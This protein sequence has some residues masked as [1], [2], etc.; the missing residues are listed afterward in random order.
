MTLGDQPSDPFDA[1]RRRFL[2]AAALG[3]AAP[4]AVT[5]RSTK[6]RAAAAPVKAIAFDG[7]VVFDP[8][9]VYA[10]LEEIFPG[11]GA[12]V[13][14]LWRTRQFEYTWLRTLTGRYADFR[15]V[16]AEALDYAAAASQLPLENAQ[17]TRLMAAW[18]G[19]KA[20]PDAKPALAAL[21]Q[22]G[23][24][25]GFLSNLTEGMLRDAVASAGLDGIFEQLLSTDRVR[26]F[27]PDPR[28]YRMGMDGFGLDR[29]EIVFAAF[30]G[31]DAA[32]AKAFGYRTYWCNRLGQPVEQLGVTPDA[33]GGD[34][35]GLTRF[36]LGT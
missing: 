4:L 15:Q 31:W 5:A 29:D 12:A 24:R 11:K 22:A 35:T 16:T 19:L 8:R 1:A 33:A 23:I 30:G 25:L 17:R 18:A 13:A 36:V 21:R 34:M 14:A 28:A 7:F 10:L 2:A 3:V 27:K 32:G 26:A 6:A 20:H 9:P